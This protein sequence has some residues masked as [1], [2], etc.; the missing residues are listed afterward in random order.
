MAVRGPESD[1]R[2]ERPGHTD[3]PASHW[4]GTHPLSL[5]L[6]PIQSTP[7]FPQLGSSSEKHTCRRMHFNV[8]IHRTN[9]GPVLLHTYLC[10]RLRSEQESWLCSRP[11]QHLRGGGKRSSRSF[12]LLS[13]CRANLGY[14]RPSLKRNRHKKP[15]ASHRHSN[16]QQ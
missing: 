9:A 8:F 3:V 1:Q 13:T 12:Q 4:A 7:K 5:A 16:W 15:T 6:S 2:V 14:I 11:S 10:C